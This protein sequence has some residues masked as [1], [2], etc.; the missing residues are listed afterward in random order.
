MP[1]AP[2][3]ALLLVLLLSGC[4]K[5]SELTVDRA[6]SGEILAENPAGPTPARDVSPR[7]TQRA[8]AA[9]ATSPGKID[10]LPALAPP[11]P[12]RDT[13]FKHYGVN[14]TI[15]TEEEN[16]SS[17]ALDV[18]PASYALARGA[19]ERED[20]PEE[21]AVR[22]EEFV[23]A[24]EYDYPAPTDED[25]AI[26]TD[27]VGS[28][29]RAGFQV[30]RIGLQARE[31]SDSDRA[32]ANLVF[33]IDTSA[34]MEK[35]DKLRLVQDSLRELVGRLGER[36][37]VAIVAYGS[38]AEVVLPPTSGDQRDE[39]IAALERLET[40]GQT[41]IDTGLRLGYGLAAA[42]AIE[43]GINRV[44][45]CT[46]GVATSGADTAEELLAHV[47]THAAR[48]ISITTIGVGV[49]D[50]DDVLL[51][52]L[53]DRGGG[54]YAHVDRLAEAKR[55]LVDNLTG[56]LQIVA[57]DAK[58]QVEF[59][60]AVVARYRLLGYENRGLSPDAFTSEHTDAGE[61]G[62]GHNVTALYEVQLRGDGAES[63]GTI[64]L[65]YRRPHTGLTAEI[66][67]PVPAQVRPSLADAEPATVLAMVVAAYAE[68]LRG[69]YWVRELTWAKIKELHGQIA[70][71]LLERPE[72]VELGELIER[73]TRLDRRS[74]RYDDIAFSQLEFERMPVLE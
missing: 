45:L 16:V 60:R 70:A 41:D 51:E 73:A 43:G 23:N 7:R 63:L 33:V 40:E 57:R 19:L 47:A 25:F 44:M 4:A 17:F 32:A 72:V 6:S 50:Y 24:F 12:P 42:A 28:P 8:D 61:I 13:Y 67:R 29:H 53:A 65:R 68:K 18:D 54:N 30:L 59:D 22:V 1:S 62:A 71:P 64:R 34:S 11:A 20:L 48:G 27:L 66:I 26:L 58:L 55:V 35:D 52:Q 9:S 74:E 21:A 14:P 31:V 37:K 15:D 38:A 5:R 36:D 56:T 46:D 69:S 10:E 39:I 2:R 3:T 49:Q